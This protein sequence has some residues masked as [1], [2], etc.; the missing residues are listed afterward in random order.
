[1]VRFISLRHR[2]LNM[3]RFI[4]L[5]HRWLNMVRFISLRHRWLNMVRFISLRHRWLNMVRFISLRHRW[6]VTVGYHSCFSP[7]AFWLESDFEIFSYSSFDFS[8][9][10]CVICIYL[11]ILV[12]NT[13][14]IFFSSIV[15]HICINCGCIISAFDPFLKSPLS[16]TQSKDEYEKISKS[17]SSQKAKDTT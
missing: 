5:R 15:P 13:I 11:C 6:Q 17:L 4:S 3:V 8:C 16:D 12:S 9:F 1:M 7:L 14:S 2:W 10:I